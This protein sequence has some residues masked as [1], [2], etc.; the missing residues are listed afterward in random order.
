MAFLVSTYLLF[1]PTVWMQR[2]M[3][4]TYLS[5]DYKIFLLVLAIFGFGCS[6]VAEKALLPRLAKRIGKI[7]ERYRPKQR[8]LYKMLQDEMRV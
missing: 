1:N 5:R 7:K 4:L 3:Q 6:W 2:F 8:K